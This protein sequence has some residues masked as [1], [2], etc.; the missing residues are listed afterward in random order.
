[1]TTA[2]AVEDARVLA[3]PREA[4]LDL[5]ARRP[6]VALGVIAAL[7]RRVRAFAT[8]VE[9]LTLR[10]PRGP[11]QAAIGSPARCQASTPPPS[12]FAFVNPR[13]WSFAA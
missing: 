12:A 10:D 2:V 3:V 6:Q 9:D 1:M 8:L 11:R 5:C 4:L 13:A 7:A